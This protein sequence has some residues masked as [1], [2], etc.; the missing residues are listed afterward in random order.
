MKLV[1]MEELPPLDDGEQECNE[2]YIV[3]IEFYGLNKA[4]YMNQDG[5]I[6]WWT[7]YAT[8]IMSNVTHWWK[9]EK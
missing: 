6:G 1:K 8:K 5:Q 3:Y 4:M 2:Y 7:S 9:L